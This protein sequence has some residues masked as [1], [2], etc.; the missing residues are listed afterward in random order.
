MA[1]H[2]LDEPSGNASNEQI[3]HGYPYYYVP[4]GSSTG[5]QNYPGYMPFHPYYMY[6]PMNQMQPMYSNQGTTGNE[7]SM[8]NSAHSSSFHLPPPPFAFA[9]NLHLNPDGSAS[10]QSLLQPGNPIGTTH[11]TSD[12]APGL[13]TTGST[14]S[15]HATTMF[16][17]GMYYPFG[18]WPTLPSLQTSNSMNDVSKESNSAMLSPTLTSASMRDLESVKYKEGAIQEESSKEADSNR[19]KVVVET[20]QEAQT[21][22]VV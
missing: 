16:A 1:G 15:I 11:P 19:S 13:P 21:E 8:P 18:Q 22:T 3:T 10:S 14:S 4:Q 20:T 9:Q 17:G 6:N 5:T 7:K 12:Q 2:V